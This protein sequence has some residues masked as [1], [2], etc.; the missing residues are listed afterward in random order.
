MSYKALYRKYRPSSFDE[1]Y[2][3]QHIIATL[4]NAVENNRLAHAYLFCGPRGTGK[5]STAKLLAKTINCTGENK[6]CGKCENCMDIQNSSHPDVIELDGATNNGVDEI[7]ELVDRVKYAPMQGKYKVYIIDE[8][9]MITANAFNA[10]L[11]TLEEPPEYCIFILCTTEPHKVLPTIVSRCQRFDFNKISPNVIQGRIKEICG[12]ENIKIS[13]KAVRIIAELAD[14]GL[15][16]ALSILDQCVAYSPESIEEED[17]LTVYGIATAREKIDLLKTVETKD[18]DTLIKMVNDLSNRGTDLRRLTVDLINMAK[19]AVIY[20]Y[21][22]NKNL[23]EKIDEKQ[24]RELLD[25]LDTGK[26]LKCI[27]CLMDVNSRYATA[28]D[29]L[30]YFEVGFLKMMEGESQPKTKLEIPELTDK[31][32]EK[33]LA[34]PI[35]EKKAIKTLTDDEFLRILLKATKEQ[36]QKDEPAW[37]RVLNC[38]DDRY[39]S[40][41]MGIKGAAI[42]ADSADSLIITVEEKIVADS[43][44]ELDQIA[45]FEEL[46]E[47]EYGTHKS[48]ICVTP[49]KCQQLIAY[50]RENKDKPLVDEPIEKPTSDENLEVTSRL[51]RLFGAEGYDETEE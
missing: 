50:F 5:T 20:S 8:V 37:N 2:G 18:V 15:R 12:K 4:K 38:V 25:S 27:D 35:K 6:P 30:S 51:A 47:K 43:L 16:D 49:E 7:R 10:L 41:V 40:I 26:L 46:V 29:S 11:K 44:N 1:V 22:G 3:Q 28:V 32:E 17:V 34:T 24:A 33:T 31:P 23:L 13:D 19:E 39:G 36:K 45:L 48:V 42:M 9:H 14:G 21:S